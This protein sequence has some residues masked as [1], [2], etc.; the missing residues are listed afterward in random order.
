MTWTAAGDSIASYALLASNQIL[1]QGRNVP[2]RFDVLDQNSKYHWQSKI[3][4]HRNIT[5]LIWEGVR[6]ISLL[7]IF[8]KELDGFKGV[9]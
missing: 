2:R 4:Q 1:Q 5:W 7:V 6:H 9:L 3:Q 8:H